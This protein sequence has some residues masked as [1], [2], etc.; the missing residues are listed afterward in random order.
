MEPAIQ[1]VWTYGDRIMDN[2]YVERYG[3]ELCQLVA[4]CLAIKPID[5]PS[6]EDLREELN[7]LRPP[8]PNEDDKDWLAKYLRRPSN[9]S[10]RP[11]A[12]A[13]G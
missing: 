6:L 13:F 12:R 5:R 9:P 11:L 10:A 1:N 7:N 3:Q 8:D 4:S 2:T